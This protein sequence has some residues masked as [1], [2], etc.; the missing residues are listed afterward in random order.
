MVNLVK[1]ILRKI[2]VLSTKGL[3]KGPHITRYYMYEHLA[4]V[5]KGLN[6]GSAGAAILSISNSQHLT[7]LLNI[8]E[9]QVIE[10]NFP[11]FD[12]LNLPF[13]DNQF[14]FVICDQILEHVEGSPQKAVDETYRV[15]K[16][17]GILVQTSCLFYGIHESPKD[18]WRF[19]PKALAL[20]CKP[21]SKIIDL[22]GWGNLRVW[23]FIWLEL[24]R[25]P[26]PHAKW[27]PLHKA[28]V[29][30]Q[31]NYPIVTWVV[32]RK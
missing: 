22:G 29:K 6:T 7:S 21:F 8:T 12:I 31:K 32:A 13:P 27:H 30:N 19:T 24:D 3:K 26:V 25:Y 10:A 17:G 9:P 5:L 20:L 28:A 11:E 15:L 16:H 1:K 14:D 18:F 23:F 4:Q 2:I